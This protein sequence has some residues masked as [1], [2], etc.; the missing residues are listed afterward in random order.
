[1][2]TRQ[3]HYVPRFYL[4]RFASKPK[5]INVYNLQ[6]AMGIEDVSLRDQCKKPNLYGDSETE[7]ALAILEDAAAKCLEAVTSNPPRTAPETLL[8]FVAIQYLRTPAIART[9]HSISQKFFGAMTDQ[10]P[11]D[12][13]IETMDSLTQ[14][15]EMPAFNLTMKDVV[16]ENI[17]DLKLT[18]ISRSDDVFITSDNPVYFHNQY[19]EQVQG[20]GTIGTRSRGLQIFMPLSPRHYLLLFDGETYDYVKSQTI[21]ASDIR[22]LNRLQVLSAEANLYFVDWGT[23][24]EVKMLAADA[25]RLRIGDPGVLQEFISGAED[26]TELIHAYV[27]TPHPELDLSFLRIKKRALRVPV[28]KRPTW[29]AIFG[30]PY[31][32]RRDHPLQRYPNRVSRL[33]GTA[34]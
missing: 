3:H 21:R 22:T 24:N 29:R 31:S 14:L 26:N 28:D 7:N 16:V 10:M 12:K 27:E 19:C 5:R 6:R 13:R 4:T 8:E 32:R 9:M 1:M 20:R 17:K 2:A 11:E 15:D 18:M 30:I 34:E 33:G 25:A 23:L